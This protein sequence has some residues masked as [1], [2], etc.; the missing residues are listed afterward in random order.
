MALLLALVR[1]Q[2]AAVDASAV[3]K[4]TPARAGPSARFGMSFLALLVTLSAVRDSER[5]SSSV[6][7]DSGSSAGSCLGLEVGDFCLSKAGFILPRKE[8]QTE[9]LAAGKHGR[10]SKAQT[11][12]A[13]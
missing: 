2:A 12:T 5:R 13:S 9:L 4:D 3:G 11:Q 10:S 1:R 6:L 8:K 7:I